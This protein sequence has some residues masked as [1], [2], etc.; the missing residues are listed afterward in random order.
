[1]IQ[2]KDR[3]GW[4][5][6]SDTKYIV[7]RW[8]S[9]TFYKWWL[10]KLGVRTSNFTNRY[11]M[12]GTHYEHRILAYLGI[13][14]M[15]KQYRKR[16]YRLRVNLDGNTSGSIHEVKTYKFENGF[17]ITPAYENQVQVEMYG[18][19]YRKAEII[20]YGLLEEDYSNYFNDIDPMRLSFHQIDYRPDFISKIYLP[21]LKYL[22]R[23]LRRGVTPDESKRVKDTNQRRR[24]GG[25]CVDCR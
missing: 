25:D 20:A 17:K 9:D 23:C 12:A 13:I 2:N 18:S 10:V 21:N 1:M 22:A 15:D 6:A 7:G 4:F 8:D 19:G 24:R 5:G 16:R 11:T 3:S 14:S